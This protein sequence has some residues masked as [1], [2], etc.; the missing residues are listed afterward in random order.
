[1][2]NMSQGGAVEAEAQG[3]LLSGEWSF[4]SAPLVDIVFD[5][6]IPA[7]S[8]LACFFCSHS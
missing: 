1:M 3:G 5:R 4:S 7:K 6:T 8:H 2:P